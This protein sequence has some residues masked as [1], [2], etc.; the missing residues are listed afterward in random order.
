M[1]TSV[2]ANITCQCVDM[3]VTIKAIKYRSSRVGLLTVPACAAECHYEYIS[4]TRAAVNSSLIKIATQH[5]KCFVV[6]VAKHI[7]QNVRD[8]TEADNGLWD[9][10]GLHFSEMGSCTL[11]KL[12]HDSI[13]ENNP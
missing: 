2:R 8:T 11:A 10:D 4:A 3:F 1:F 13:I 9:Q 7:P 6:D 5:P 12:V